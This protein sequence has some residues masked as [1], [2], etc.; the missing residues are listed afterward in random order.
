MPIGLNVW[1]ETDDD[2]LFYISKND[3]ASE[4][5]CLLKLGKVRVKLDPN[6]CCRYAL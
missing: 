2:L 6:L 1:T 4:N 5:D 3:T